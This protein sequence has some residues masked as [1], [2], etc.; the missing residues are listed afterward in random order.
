MRVRTVTTVE[1][2]VSV[3]KAQV[4][5][6]DHSVNKFQTMGSK[7]II[8]AAIQPPSHLKK[9][10]KKLIGKAARKLQISISSEQQRK[11][12]R[13]F[14]KIQRKFSTKDLANGGDGSHFGDVV[15]LLETRYKKE[16]IKHFNPHVPYL[17]SPSV[18]SFRLDV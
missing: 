1:G 14:Q 7:E 15:S 11:T 10:P 18:R 6:G 8:I 3:Y 12:R 13:Q 9:G 2:V 17:E 16:N 5:H 4:N